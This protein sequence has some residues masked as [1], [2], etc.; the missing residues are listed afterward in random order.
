MMHAGGEG[1]RT[2]TKHDLVGGAHTAAHCFPLGDTGLDPVRAPRCSWGLGSPPAHGSS[3]VQGPWKV[4][5]PWG[6]GLV[7]GMCPTAVTAEVRAGQG[8][9]VPWMGTTRVLILG[10]S[11]EISCARVPRDP[12]DRVPHSQGWLC[13]G[14][15][16]GRW[17]WQRGEA[18]VQ[19]Q[20]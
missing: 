4:L 8:M 15:G 11:G 17:P 18:A 14:G 1:G 3:G 7:L 6:Q 9:L 5:G 13:A 16:C 12:Q 20:H 19:C 2:E 10:P